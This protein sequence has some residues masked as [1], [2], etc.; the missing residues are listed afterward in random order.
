MLFLATV[1]NYLDRQA[2]SILAPELRDRF[3]M[4]NVDYSRILFASFWRTSSCRA[5]PGG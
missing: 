5:S 3:H 1:I 2:L 4:T